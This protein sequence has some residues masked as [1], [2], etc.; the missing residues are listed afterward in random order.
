[1]ASKVL[2]LLDRFNEAGIILSLSVMMI[3]VL[4]QVFARF[5]LDSAP[6]W[7]EE[8]ARIFFVFSVA[9]GAGLAVKEGAYIFLDSLIHWL[10]PG[11][12]SIL[13]IAGKV[14]VILTAIVMLVY[15]FNFV[16]IGMLE[17]SPAMN[18]NMGYVFTSMPIMAAMIGAYTIL[19]FKKNDKELS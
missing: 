16:A 12:R 15:S 8:M 7:T 2:K 18:I 4:I 13:A 6:S 14:T 19:S 17:T 3:S 5:F 9:F 10:K 1:M 11:L